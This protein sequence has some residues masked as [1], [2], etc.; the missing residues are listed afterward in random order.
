[1]ILPLRSYERETPSRDAKSVFIFCEGKKREFQYFRYFRDLDSRINIKVY[2]LNHNDDNSPKGLLEIANKCFPTNSE[3]IESE[4]SFVEGDEVWIVLDCDKDK[5]ESRV[6][7]IADI[8]KECSNK[9][10]WYVA[11]S[12]PCFEVWLYYHEFAKKPDVLSEKP[13][14]WKQLVATEIKGGFDSKRHPLL[15]KTARDNARNNYAV[16]GNTPEVGCTDV[17]K[18]ADTILPLVKEKLDKALRSIE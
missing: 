5:R 15:I 13:I 16:V 18:L 6:P 11:I 9:I 1:M 3:N 2:E 14:W 4:Y 17:F 10:G 12:N 7:Q 8:I